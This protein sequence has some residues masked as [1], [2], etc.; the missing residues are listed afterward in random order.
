MGAGRQPFFTVGYSNHSLQEFVVLLKKHGISAVADVRSEPYSR[1]NPQFNR[2]TLSKELKLHGIEY[3]FMGRELGARSEDSACYEDGRV[4]YE[5]LARTPLFLEGIDR[6]LHGAS[7]Y[8]I[9]LMCAEKDPI[10]CHRALLVARKIF[11]LGI[12]VFHIINEDGNIE[13]HQELEARLLATCR[14]PE[15]DFFNSREDFISQAYLIQGNRI[16]FQDK[17]MKQEKRIQTS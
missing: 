17:A 7:K 12:P 2:E 14:L 8:K 16:A 5:L 11:E 9:T 6:L 10:Q 13:S 3:V 15:E 1:F 4:Q